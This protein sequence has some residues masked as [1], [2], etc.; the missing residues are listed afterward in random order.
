MK[1]SCCSL[2]CVTN[3]RTHMMRR[4]DLILCVYCY[5]I[6]Y[7]CLFVCLGWLTAESAVFTFYMVEQ[8]FD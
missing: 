8:V 2:V 5:S 4:L 7:F 3:T 6:I 1:M